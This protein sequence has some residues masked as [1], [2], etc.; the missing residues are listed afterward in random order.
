MW[1]T[2]CFMAR[3]V[4]TFRKNF[5]YLFFRFKHSLF[6]ARKNVFLVSRPLQLPHLRLNSTDNHQT[7]LISAAGFL[8]HLQ[9][10]LLEVEASFSTLLN[11]AWRRFLAPFKKFILMMYKVFLLHFPRLWKDNN[12]F[13]YH[14]VETILQR[15]KMEKIPLSEIFSCFF[16]A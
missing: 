14:E 13:E 10:C 9:K 5:I 15:K 8:T 2:N 3:S 7:R 16:N 11:L 6:H 1:K 4:P 12:N